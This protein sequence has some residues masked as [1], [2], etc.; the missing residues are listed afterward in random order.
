MQIEIKEIEIA[1]LDLCYGHTRIRDNRAIRRFCASLETH[2]QLTPVVV[3]PRE[4]IGHILLDGYLRV[5]ALKRLGRDFVTAE[6]HRREAETLIRIICHTQA[7]RW[8]FFEYAEVIK[9][10]MLR[11]DYSQA[12]IARFLG[13]SESFISRRLQVLESLDEEMRE[14]VRKGHISIWS[15]TR[16]LAPLARANS[17]HAGQLA[18]HIIAYPYTTRE[19]MDWF[20]AYRKA[21]SKNRSVMVEN[22]RMVLDA[23]KVRAEEKETEAIRAGPEGRWTKDIEIITQMLKRLTR[24]VDAVFYENQAD[25]DRRSLMTAFDTSV[26][27]FAELTERIRRAN[28]IHRNGKHHQGTASKGDV[29]PKNQPGFAAFQENGSAR[30]ERNKTLSEQRVAP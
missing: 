9:E 7:R 17:D 6:I 12:D 27:A 10:M 24:E 21:T 19:L 26:R 25:L 15:A 18:R 2:G 23:L 11:F 1:H 4:P 30:P 16:V 20:K 8:E 29:H 14:H 28:A 22:P 3:V 5:A 13:K